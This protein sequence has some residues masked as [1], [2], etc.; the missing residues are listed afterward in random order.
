MS[1]Q[2]PTLI[3]SKLS[4]IA[5]I[6]KR[7]SSYAAG[8]DLYTPTSGVVE[9]GQRLLVK[10]DIAIELPQGT[11]GHILPRSGLALKNGIHIGAGVV[12]EDYR[13]NVGVLLFNLGNEP[14][15]FNAGDRIAQLVVKPYVRVDVFENDTHAL[16]ESERGSGGFGSSGR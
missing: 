7:G 16:S 6:P 3:V 12:D 15:V 9:P 13:G 11:F 2:I 10:L 8:L 4:T 1:E 14:Y 5:I